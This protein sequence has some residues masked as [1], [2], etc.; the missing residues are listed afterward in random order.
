M[1]H[2][3]QG[4]EQEVP[5]LQHCPKLFISAKTG[6]NVDKI[7]D[8]IQQVYADS[9]KRIPTHQLN[10]FVSSC[11]QKNHPPMLMGKR[12]RIYYMAQVSIQP[13][14]FI[15]FVNY[16]NLMTDTY[17]KY[18]Y[19]QFRE[20]YGFLGVPILIFLKGKQKSKEAPSHSAEN[21]F[22]SEDIED[23]LQ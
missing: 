21:A 2:C 10:K 11:L 15:L 5:F 8:L 20:T 18:L 23:P 9:Q 12:L 17:K 19:N 1:E 4:I 14:T 7:F 16:P 3:L 22:I 6:R 13:P